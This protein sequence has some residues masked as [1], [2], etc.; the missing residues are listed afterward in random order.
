MPEL[1][2][3]TVTFLFTDVEGSTRLWESIPQRCGLPSPATTSSSP[4]R[5]RRTDGVVFQTGR[6]RRLCLP[7]SPRASDALAAALD[8]QRALHAEPWGD[9]GPLKVRMALHTG[10][11]SSSRTATTS[12]RASTAAPASR[13]RARR[14]GAALG[15]D[16][17]AGPR[18]P[19]R[20]VEPARTSASSGSET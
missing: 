20:G 3:G 15:G 4:E 6:R 12:A 1:P 7:S 11:A 14:A 18:R 17:G 16:R 10:E 5:S 19:A 13:D 2:I 8:A 9:T